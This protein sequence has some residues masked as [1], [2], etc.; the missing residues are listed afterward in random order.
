MIDSGSHFENNERLQT[1]YQKHDTWLRKVAMNLSGNQDVVD[2]LVQELYLYLGEKCNPQLYYLDSFNLKYCHSFLN[3]RWNNLINREKKS[4]YSSDFK[5]IPVE[6]YDDTWDNQL[7]QFEQ[8]VVKEL[9]RLE[10][11]GD[12]ASAKLYRMYIF[13]DKSMEDLSTDIGISKST[14]FLSVKKIKLHL[15]EKINKPIKPNE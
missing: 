10:K 13:G 2:D 5:S 15:Q 12:W 11:T 4:I 8:D 3:S 14:L 9:D 1:L 6:E 7:Y